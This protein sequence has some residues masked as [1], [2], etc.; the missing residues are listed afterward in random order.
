[1]RLDSIQE[2]RCSFE[3]LGVPTLY[4]FQSLPHRA[5]TFYHLV[6]SYLRLDDD[7][8][9]RHEAG[10]GEEEE[11]RHEH[12]VHPIFESVLEHLEDEEA[13]T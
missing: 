4:T 12:L 3:L 11:I 9:H 13:V 7:R 5:P 1:M 8:I 2:Q 10:G 6:H